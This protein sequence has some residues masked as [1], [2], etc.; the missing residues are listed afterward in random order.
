MKVNERA[1]RTVLEQAPDTLAPPNAA[2]D[3]G[4]IAK[5][6]SDSSFG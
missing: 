1:S 5:S 2:T 3:S 4:E 6:G